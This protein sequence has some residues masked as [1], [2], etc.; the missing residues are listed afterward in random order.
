MGLHVQKSLCVCFSLKKDECNSFVFFLFFFPSS[1]YLCSLSS[2]AASVACCCMNAFQDWV[3]SPES[4]SVLSSSISSSSSL[5]ASWVPHFRNWTCGT[6][7]LLVLMVERWT[8]SFAVIEMKSILWKKK[9][10]VKVESYNPLLAEGDR[11]RW[12]RSTQWPF[13][14]RQRARWHCQLRPLTFCWEADWCQ[15]SRQTKKTNRGLGKTCWQL[16]EVER[17]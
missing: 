3:R 8:S 17:N 13:W 9:S 6:N 4:W 15:W 16:E 11:E 1:F 10:L 14:L 5:E 2:F 7:C 12:V